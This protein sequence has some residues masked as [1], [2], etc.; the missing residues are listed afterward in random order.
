MA[1]SYPEPGPHG[2]ST[3]PPVRARRGMVAAAHPMAAQAGL[4]MLR[5]GG[6]ALDAIVAVASTLNVVEPYMS[7]VGGIGVALLYVA[8]EGRTRV[9]NFSG[10]A[11]RKARPELYT[12]ETKETGIIAPLVP[13]NLLGWLTMHETYGRLPRKVLFENAIDC[14]Q[15]GFPLSRFNAEM[16]ATQRKRLSA[17]PSTSRVAYPRGHVPVEGELFKQPDLASSLSEIAEGGSDTFYTGRLAD[18]IISFVERNGGLLSR[19]DL[20]SERVEWQEPLEGRY[21]GHQVRVAPPNSDGFQILETL[22]VLEGFED[23]RYGTPS[24]LHVLMEAIK[25]GI[26]DRLAYGGDPAFV[27]IPLD[28]LLSREYAAKRRQQIDRREATEP[29]PQKYAREHLAAGYPDMPQEFADGLTTHFAAADSEGNVVT[30]TQTLGSGFGSGVIAGDTG[31][32]LNN[33]CFFFDV[34]PKAPSPNLIAGGKRVDLCL[35]PVQVFKDGKI[36]LSIGTPGGYGI[37]Q[38][39]LQMLHHFLDC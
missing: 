20:A 7:G 19:E 28:T 23:L 38:T 36:R 3:R 13:G 6:T 8:S 33:M 9:L 16:L 37:L 2:R 12:E 35:S 10:R 24:T 31:I 15:H 22:N 29:P 39:T 21:R 26:Y 17:F 4:D 5:R 32:F 27:K 11:A 34:D 25:I 14:A 18:Q 30:V 1:R